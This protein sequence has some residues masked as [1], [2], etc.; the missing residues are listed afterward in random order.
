MNE[1]VQ[2]WNLKGLP[3]VSQRMNALGAAMTGATIRI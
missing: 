2:E 1:D 3:E